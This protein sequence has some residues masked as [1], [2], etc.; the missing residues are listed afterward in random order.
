[1]ERKLILRGAL[2]GAAAGLIAFA[3]ARIFAE[4]QIQA[5]IDYESGRDAAQHALDEAAGLPVEHGG[6]DIFS[7]TL[8]ANIGIGVGV[9]LFGVAMGALFAVAYAI[10]LGRVGKLRPR[11]L[12]MLVALGG[13]LGVYLVP[14]LKYPANPPAI[15]HE[16]TI[17]DR[18]NLYLAMVACSIV[19]LIGAVL[20]GKRLQPRFGN[21]NATLLAIAA[22]VVIIGVLMAVLPSVGQLAANVEE[23]GRHATETPLPLT[24]DKGNIVFPGFDAD[25]LYRFRLYS[26][27]AQV[28]L[29]SAIGLIFGPL[30]ER[31]LQPRTARTEQAEPVRNA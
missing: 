2:A 21:W 29:W 5:A 7:R 1:M 22:Y 23:Y 14:F 28:L 27:A 9:I 10:C 3:F 13:F 26:V 16:D 15:G 24:D 12:A 25:T 19:L 6:H 4:P 18:S 30:A 17:L 31:L 8:Q 20:L 11:N